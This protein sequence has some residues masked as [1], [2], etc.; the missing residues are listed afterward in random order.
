MTN[1]FDANCWC[2]YVDDEIRE[3]DGVG[4]A[5]FATAKL[6]G[7]YLLDS[8]GHGRQ[9]Y[10][11]M[12]RPYAEQIFDLWA[13]GVVMSGHLKLVDLDG[14]DNLFKELSE[15]GI[16]KKEHIFFKTA[17]HGGAAFIIS[18][19][20]DFFDPSKKKCGE[21]EKIALLASGR[22]PV[23]KHMRKKHDITICCPTTFV[24]ID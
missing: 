20:S 12:R 21:E 6:K 3:S 11:D 2:L 19:D 23:C 5:I 15:I 4:R 13:E 8:G 7:G 16:P 14:K 10:I 9:Q 17:V 1:V 18:A 24:A 22:G